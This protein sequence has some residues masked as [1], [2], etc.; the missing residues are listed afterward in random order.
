ML[1]S[2]YDLCAPHPPFPLCV[3]PPLRVTWILSFHWKYAFFLRLSSLDTQSMSS[4]QAVNPFQ[5]VLSGIIVIKE[6]WQLQWPLYKLPEGIVGNPP[7]SVICL[8]ALSAVP[9]SGDPL[10][11]MVPEPALLLFPTGG[12]FL[13]R[14]GT[15]CIFLSH[16]GLRGALCPRGSQRLEG[17]VPHLP[18]HEQCVFHVVVCPG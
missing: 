10:P 13:L 9:S 16:L 15:G 4:D 8:R 12:L 18:L 6:A 14:L 1:F 7:P 2:V 3:P 17:G 5:K 11:G